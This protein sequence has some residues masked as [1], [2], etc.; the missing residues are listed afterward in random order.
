MQSVMK[1]VKLMQLLLYEGYA[2]IG[3]GHASFES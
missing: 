2:N 3:M 1:L